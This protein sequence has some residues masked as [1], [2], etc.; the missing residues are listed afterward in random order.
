MTVCAPQ[1]HLV[2]RV[3]PHVPAPT[4]I[5]MCTGGGGVAGAIAGVNDC[6]LASSQSER[7]ELIDMPRGI[8][9]GPPGDGVRNIVAV[10]DHHVLGVKA[11]VVAAGIALPV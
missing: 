8:P 7:A 5:Q 2:A 1:D 4:P 9:H 6:L 3:V 10:P 11:G